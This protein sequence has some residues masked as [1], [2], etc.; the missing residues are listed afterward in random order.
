MEENNK[1]ESTSDLVTVSKNTLLQALGEIRFSKRKDVKFEKAHYKRISEAIARLEQ[2]KK[3]EEFSIFSFQIN[4]SF[5]EKK[6]KQLSKLADVESKKYL[7]HYADLVNSE[8]CSEE[9]V[10]NYFIN[11]DIPENLFGFSKEFFLSLL[12][13]LVLFYISGKKSEKDKEE[14]LKAIRDI[15]K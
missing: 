2:E 8:K 9:V 1:S 3:L 11:I 15:K 6:F 7:M 13:T 4:F 12:I 5:N 14:I 10:Y